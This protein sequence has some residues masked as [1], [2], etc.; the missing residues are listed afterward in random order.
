[1][2]EEKKEF[3]LKEFTL[4]ELKKFHIL[5]RL[6]ECSGDQKKTAKSLGI[7][8][9]TLWRRLKEYGVIGPRGENK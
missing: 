2:K 9:T 4:K 8:R 5:K 7:G 3:T 6:E 1:M